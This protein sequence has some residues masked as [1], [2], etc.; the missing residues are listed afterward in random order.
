MP[1]DAK[2]RAVED[3]TV[4]VALIVLLVPV[5]VETIAKPRA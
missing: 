2:M 1:Q 5:L 4:D 3:V